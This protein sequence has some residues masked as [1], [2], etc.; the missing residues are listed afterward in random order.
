MALLGAYKP[1]YETT[2]SGVAKQAPISSVVSLGIIPAVGS[3]GG[4]VLE[5]GRAMFSD[6][7]DPMAMVKGRTQQVA[8]ELSDYANGKAGK[9]TISV[10]QKK[11]TIVPAPPALTAAPEEVKPI[12]DISN[13]TPLNT[14]LPKIDMPDLQKGIAKN[15]G[16]QSDNSAVYNDPLRIQEFNRAA[17]NKLQN[18]QRPQLQ[19][20]LGLN[21]YINQLSAM[22]VAKASRAP[23]K[24][25]GDSRDQMMDEAQARKEANQQNARTNSIISVAGSAIPT[26]LNLPIHKYQIDASSETANQNILASTLGKTLSEDITMPLNAMKVDL[27]KSQIDL[28]KAHE[29][30]YTKTTAGIQSKEEQSAANRAAK[31]DEIIQN[32]KKIIS[33]A[34]TKAYDAAITAGKP[35]AEAKDHAGRIA[36]DTQDILMGKQFMPGTPAQASTGILGFGTP[37]KPAVAGKF[38]SYKAP[39]GMTYVG[40]SG[41]K[42]VYQD[43][44]G[45]RF[46]GK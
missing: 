44:S 37:E 26:A 9:P 6:T 30:H 25:F 19:E 7:G 5:T 27:Q 35:E 21:D 13:T 33:E 15:S 42:D 40:T 23:S 45:N 32:Q 38:V 10:P 8:D 17:L 36:Q 46:T 22:P 3:L 18:P 28:N 12:S 31:M 14:A 11:N 1:K 2:F 43:A 29:K 41:G 24:F 39:P 16:E 34:Y 4:K 20:G